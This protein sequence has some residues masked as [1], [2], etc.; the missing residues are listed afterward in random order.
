MRDNRPME[1]GWERRHPFVELPLAELKRLVARAMP[2]S[3][4][5]AARPLT[6]GLR[7]TNYRIELA[8][9]MA[10]VL[11]L[12]VADREAC[13]REAAVLAAMAGLVPAPR[14]LYSDAMADPPFALLEW[15]DGM[16]LH[17]VL[18]VA[19]SAAALDLAGVC[20]AALATIHSVRFAAPG[21]LGPGLRA[22]RPMPSW[23]P[24]VVETLNGPIAER[25]GPEL[26]AGVRET[27]RSNADRVEAVWS[28]AVLV[29][30]D[31]KPWNLLVRRET[32]TSAP[33]PGAAAPP[34]ASAPDPRLG[35]AVSGWHLTGILDWEFACAGCKLIDFATFLRDEEAR[36]AG[37]GDAF[38]AA[39]L[40]AGATLPNDW[41]GLARL[42]DLL[43][44]VQLLESGDPQTTEDLRR[45]VAGTTGGV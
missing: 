15:L 27:V 32:P 22:V 4:V 26:A 24:T 44:L 11:R 30:A 13:G 8:G 36:P 34:E 7:N 1:R 9:G 20:G 2:G 18:D 29:H 6:A 21:F 31:Y 42:V 45:L 14:V 19:D 39:Y 16:P 35:A 41:R 12:Y 25:L 28:E 10:A 3:D 38:A 43:N 33:A 5:V 37:F 40:A 23:A 17:E